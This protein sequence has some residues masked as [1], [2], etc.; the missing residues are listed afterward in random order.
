MK[1]KCLANETCPVA[2]GYDA[3]GDWWSLLI[4]LNILTH[5]SRRF[6]QLQEELGMAKNIL[7][8]R[9]KKL[10]DED[11]LEKRPLAEGAYHEYA[12]TA[13]GRDLWKVLI[14]LRQWGEQYYCHGERPPNRLVD[15]E[16]GQPI[17]PVEIRAAD[18]RLLGPGDLA[19]IACQPAGTA[20][21]E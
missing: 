19:V 13:R 9:L 16:T 1:R 18:G 3:I 7:T 15:R 11:I 8:A 14:T 10:V 17:P 2:R 5:G 4:V 6:S 12:P 21:T 20:E